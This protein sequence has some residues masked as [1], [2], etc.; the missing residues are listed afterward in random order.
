MD[1]LKTIKNRRSVRKYKE[2]EI[3]PRVLKKLKEAL[4]WAP[5]AGNLQSR[6]F[7]FVFNSEIKSRLAEA[8]FGQ[9]YVEEAPLAVVACIDFE[10]EKKYG[11]EGK[12]FYSIMDAS[13]G[14]ENMLLLAHELGLGAC[15]TV[16]DRKKAS[17]ILNLPDN[18][19][20]VSVIPIGYPDE[21]PEAPER[22]GINSIEEIG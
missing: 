6:K 17:K 10:I 12:N 3:E 15:W 20:A 8:S 18:L 7:Y 22:A 9:K 14:I 2:K 13:A 1:I 5:S 16:L 19:Q 4:I 21:E 11:S